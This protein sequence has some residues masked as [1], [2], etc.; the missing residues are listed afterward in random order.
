MKLRVD[1]K[2]LEAWRTALQKAGS[3]EIGGVLFGEHVDQDDFRIVAA[4][5]QRRMGDEVAFRRKARTA[6][7]ELKR[8]SARHGHN[9][10]RFNYLGEWH[11][12]P[13]A[14]AV[15]S[16]RDCRTI[17]EI[18]SHPD[19]DAIFLVLLIVRLADA[20]SLEM[21]AHSFLASGHVLECEIQIQASNS[22]LDFRT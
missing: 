22:K 17:R 3:K 14:P 16:E 20:D 7:R 2:M 5:Q 4:T 8:M 1:S 21:S 11:S 19:T 13:N 10:E 9:H 18:L 12:H 6:R 15:P